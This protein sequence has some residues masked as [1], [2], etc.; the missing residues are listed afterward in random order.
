MTISIITTSYNYS[1]YIRD[2][3]ESVLN[4]TYTDFEYIIFDDGSTDNSL[5]I[6]ESYAKK[7]NRIKLYT[8]PNNEN[9]GLIATNIAAIQKCKENSDFGSGGGVYCFS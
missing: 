3:I 4:Q 9:R 7:D 1:K 5:E 6:I 2:T 8:H